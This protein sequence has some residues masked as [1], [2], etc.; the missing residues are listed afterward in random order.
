MSNSLLKIICVFGVSTTW[1]AYDLEKGGWV[2]RLRLYFD[3]KGHNEAEVYNLG[4]TGETT[5]DVL[6]R[7]DEEAEAREANIII[8][9][10]GANDQIWDTSK[11]AFWV[12]IEEFQ[13]NMKKLIQRARKYTQAI[14]LVGIQNVDEA[15]TAP[16]AWD[17][18]LHYKNE[19]IQKYN[20][21]LEQISKE[22]S[23]SYIPLFGLLNNED[24]EDG[25]HANAAGHQKI[26]EKVKG[27][28]A[29]NKLI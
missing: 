20:E 1:G 25:L 13:E 23:L 29:E 28:L 26:F 9:A 16:I 6:Q 10:I 2:N 15:R 19:N 24:L 4:V 27:F 5:K 11:N 7:F 14:V 21:A 17:Q 22:E 12:D 3:S 18:N 8:F